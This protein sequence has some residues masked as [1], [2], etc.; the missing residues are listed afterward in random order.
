MTMTGEVTPALD[1]PLR[2]Q[3]TS[4]GYCGAKLTAGVFGVGRRDLFCHTPVG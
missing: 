2:W 3:E 4:T 1:Q